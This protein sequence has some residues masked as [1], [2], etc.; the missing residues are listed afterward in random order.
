MALPVR[1]TTASPTTG[2]EKWERLMHCLNINSGSRSMEVSDQ[3]VK[4]WR[5]GK[6]LQKIL[7]ATETKFTD[8]ANKSSQ[9]CS[10][11]TWKLCVHRLW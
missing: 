3:R 6:S 1:G 8:L 10:L 7:T 5:E 4:A 2:V 11:R 9:K